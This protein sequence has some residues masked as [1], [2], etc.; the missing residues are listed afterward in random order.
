MD[1]LQALI[2]AAAA[3][4]QLP[5][6]L[7]TAVVAVESGGNPC[8]IR[9]EPEFDKRYNITP[10]TPFIPKGSTRATEEVARAT[11]WGLMQVMGET[12]RYLGFRRWLPELC[13]PAVGL[14]WGCRLL[15][16]LVDRYFLDWGW[17]GVVAA[18]NAGSP[19]R[20][21][22]GQFVNQAYVGK[23]LKALGGRWPAEGDAS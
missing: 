4:H 22:D 15:R 13:V 11:S 3:E 5:R 8:A 21:D 23:V 10:G 6:E 9:Y 19:R 12:S 1:E 20:T 7:V 2:D 14:Y 17:P 16:R 18:Y